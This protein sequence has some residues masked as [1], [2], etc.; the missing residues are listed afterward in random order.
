MSQHSKTYTDEQLREEYSRLISSIPPVHPPNNADDWKGWAE[1]YNWG[2]KATSEK[3]ILLEWE[4][5]KL[6]KRIEELEKSPQ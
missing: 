3:C 4:I 2:W 5:R 1:Y 6:K